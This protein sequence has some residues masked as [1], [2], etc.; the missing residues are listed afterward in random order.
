MKLLRLYMKNYAGIKRASGLDEICIDFS[1]CISNIVLI[2]GPNGSGKT[3][4]LDASSPLP[5][6]NSSM[7]DGKEGIK[8]ISYIDN[9]VIYNLRIV[10]PVKYDGTRSVIKGFI[11]KINPGGDTEELN[12]NGNITSY[13]D[14]IY[15]LFGLDPNY[16]SLTKLSMDDRGIVSKSPNERKRFVTAILESVEVYNNIYKTLSKRASAFKSLINSAASK[17]SAIGNEEEL[18]NR[19]VALEERIKYL[20][21]EK[22]TYSK[23]LSDN[24]ASVK[25][26]DPDGSIQEKYNNIVIQIQSLSAEKKNL[27]LIINRYDYKD[28]EDLLKNINSL[29]SN[30]TNIERDINDLRKENEIMLSY[31]SK[32]DEQLKA[33]KIKLSTLTADG[34]I[35]ILQNKL[36]SLIKKNEEIKKFIPDNF[37]INIS[38]TEFAAGMNT[39]NLIIEDINRIKEQAFMENLKYIYDIVSNGKNIVDILKETRLSKLASEDKIRELKYNISLCDNDIELMKSLDKRPSGCNDDSCPF[40]KSAVEAQKRDPL[41]K[42][43]SLEKELFDSQM[44]LTIYSDTIVELEDDLD[45]I[46]R[47]N[48]ILRSIE[49]NKEIFMQIGAS[50]ILDNN[51]VMKYLISEFDLNKATESVMNNLEIVNQMEL[52]KNNQTEIDILSTK[53]DALKD[54]IDLINELNSDIKNLSEKLNDYNI[55]IDENNKNIDYLSKEFVSKSTQLNNLEELNRRYDEYGMVCDKI[56]TLSSNGSVLSKDIESIRTCLDNINKLQSSINNFN[57]ELEPAQKEQEEIK[58]SL[59]MLDQYQKEL[60]LLNLK[61]EKVEMV[62]KY[63]S[64]SKGIQTLYMELY[65]GKTLKIAN[66]L[67]AMLF[68]GDLVLMDYIINENEFRIPVK[69]LSSSIIND[70]IKSCS[71]AQRSMIS[72]IISLALSMQGSGKCNIIRLDEV[73]SPL[74]ESN[75]ASFIPTIN[76]MMMAMNISQCLMISHSSESELS[77]VDIISLNSKYEGPGNVIFQY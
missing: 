75:R 4:I 52:Y 35:S 71:S 64:P 73:D 57:S 51:N 47:L 56:N 74:D 39:L 41:K 11:T 12:S 15:S 7:V 17:I 30:I 33:K 67:L 29:K 20:T 66:E 31:L 36:D 24:E 44:D 8:E 26:L 34:N 50:F 63:S 54:K 27:E 28:R 25:V 23:A 37:N 40:I 76:K 53:L 62:R 13:K 48:V 68:D 14:T 2:I 38:V 72:M 21:I 55:K 3:T 18:K 42:K 45:I 70:D 6:S 61:Y 43:E 77:N 69:S 16:V 49:S 32:D 10:H 9:D 59:K 65:M 60:E 19:L 1:K 46:N 22:E 58:F 5:D